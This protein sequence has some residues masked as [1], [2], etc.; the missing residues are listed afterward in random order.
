M[1]QTIQCGCVS[2]PR[3]T[4]TSGS[5]MLTTKL[6][7]PSGTFVHLSS[8]DTCSPACVYLTGI[9]WPSGQAV[10][11]RIIGGARGGAGAGVAC[12]VNGRIA[13]KHTRAAIVGV[14]MFVMD[15]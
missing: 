15:V 12:A 10:V 14:F 3:C 5:S 2:V 11:V 9:C 6:T 7:V 4:E 1:F 13:V 8:G